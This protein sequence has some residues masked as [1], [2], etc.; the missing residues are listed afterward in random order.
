MTNN[1]PETSNDAVPIQQVF[2]EFISYQRAENNPQTVKFYLQTVGD[3]LLWLQENSLTS[4]TPAHV[5]KYVVAL[6]DYNW[7]P[8]HRPRRFRKARS[9]HTRAKYRRG[10]RA[11]CKF[12]SERGH[13][14]PINIRVKQPG[15][16]VKDSF[17]MTEFGSLFNACESDR[18][19]AMLMLLLDAGV[20]ASEML[21]IDWDDIH[22][23]SNQ[24]HIRT[25][26]RDDERMIDI[27]DPTMK[28]LKG[29]PNIGGAVFR[30]RQGRRLKYQGL[31]KLMDKL[32]RKQGSRPM[33]INLA[34]LISQWHWR[35][36]RLCFSY[37]RRSVIGKPKLH[38]VTW[39]LRPT[40]S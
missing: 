21:G 10:I 36:V 4:I 33:L 30:N 17:T 25:A 23:D 2:D 24:I 40:T 22:W 8:P 16:K 26:K 12:A 28:L 18:D 9:A 35:K 11:F 14:E 13:M 32:E 6:G 19:K 3:F 29:L 7:H 37:R 27:D 5:D 34:G 1:Q 38:A 15:T 20:R 39:L 31:R